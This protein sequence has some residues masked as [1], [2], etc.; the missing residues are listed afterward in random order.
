[1]AYTPRT[2][3][4]ALTMACRLL[5]DIAGE[6]PVSRFEASSADRLPTCTESGCTDDADGI[7]WRE[8]LLS[9]RPCETADAL[10]PDADSVGGPT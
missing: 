3:D 10:P 7:C 1:M 2:P 4:E 6:C 9:G 8:W 5:G